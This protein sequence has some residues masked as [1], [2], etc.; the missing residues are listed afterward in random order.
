MKKEEKEEESGGLDLHLGT[1]EA[2]I[3]TSGQSDW[4]RGEALE[5]VGE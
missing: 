3:S 5:A 2:E 4:D 1:E